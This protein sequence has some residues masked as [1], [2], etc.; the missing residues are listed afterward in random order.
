[1]LDEINFVWGYFFIRIR[2]RKKKS[3]DCQPQF[4]VTSKSVYIPIVYSLYEKLKIMNDDK[5]L[6][7]SVVSLKIRG[8]GGGGNTASS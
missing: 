2:I 1:M 3:A 7:S 8:G 5:S 6:T 4:Q